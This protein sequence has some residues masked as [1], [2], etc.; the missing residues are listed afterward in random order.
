M[1]FKKAW[2]REKMRNSKQ[3]SRNIEDKRS[4]LKQGYVEIWHIWA[5]ACETCSRPSNDDLL[6]I[7][8]K[9]QQIIDIALVVST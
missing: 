7:L 4:L 9:R 5:H 1:L 3:T 2:L 6:A 8:V